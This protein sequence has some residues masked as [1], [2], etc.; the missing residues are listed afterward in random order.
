MPN[1]SVGHSRQFRT[2]RSAIAR[3]G[4]CAAV[5]L[6]IGSLAACSSSSYPSG[7]PAST[8]TRA[9]EASP[10]VAGYP[11][12]LHLDPK[13]VFTAFV[14]MQYGDGSASHWSLGLGYS[15]GGHAVQLDV[16][17]LASTPDQVRRYCAEIAGPAA[18]FM[19]GVTYSLLVTGEVK[20]ESAASPGSVTFQPARFKSGSCPKPSGPL[21]DPVRANAPRTSND[22]IDRFLRF[23]DK[24]YSEVGPGHA[25]AWYAGY[26]YA[27]TGTNISVGVRDSTPALGT[28]RCD[29]VRPLGEW[30]LGPF[31]KQ[32]TL[33][34]RGA[35]DTGSTS[36]PAVNCPQ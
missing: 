20:V 27:G 23:L 32:F 5:L 28:K 34:V 35:S 33:Q 19:K 24:Y 25:D 31:A 30:L 29:T 10:G 2:A 13:R 18:F 6:G 17:A 1:G 3:V 8:T 22:A 26:A 14:D 7:V 36:W 16:D 21:V 4:M 15:E 12:A 9:G 11:T